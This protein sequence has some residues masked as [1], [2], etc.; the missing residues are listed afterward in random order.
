MNDTA[1]TDSGHHATPGMLPTAGAFRALRQAFAALQLPDVDFAHQTAEKQIAAVR[2]SIERHP[3]GFWREKLRHAVDVARLGHQDVLLLRFAGSSCADGGRAI[4][5]A[6]A[7]WAASLTGE[8]AAPAMG[9]ADYPALEAAP[10][11]YVLER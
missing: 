3:D 5:N 1:T 11:R 9:S 2:E 10:G 6:E 8:A 7:D 4:S